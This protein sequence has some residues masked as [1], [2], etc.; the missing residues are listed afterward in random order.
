MHFEEVSPEFREESSGRRSLQWK[1]GAVMLLILASA[2]GGLGVYAALF[3][4]LLLP[5]KL[6]P[7]AVERTVRRAELLRELAKEG[8]RPV[9]V[10]GSSVVLEGVD[11]EIIEALLPGDTAVYNIAESNAGLRNLMMNMP[12]IRT[13]QPQVL[14]CCLRRSQLDADRLSELPSELLIGYAYA[15]YVDT[16]NHQPAWIFERLS[17]H[18]REALPGTAVT[19]LLASRIFLLRSVEEKLRHLARP[20]L[21]NEGFASNFVSPWRYT[22]QVPKDRLERSI[23]R[24]GARFAQLRFDPES[25][26]A[27]VLKANLKVCQQAGIRFLLVLTPENPLIQATL[28]KQIGDAFDAAVRDFTTEHGGEMFRM[29][30]N[31]FSPGDFLDYVH[32]NASGREIFSRALAAALAGSK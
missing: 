1:A 26:V 8:S 5:S 2:A 29:D 23:R 28:P 15:D 24:A 18:E 6:V 17:Q 3:T 11:S 25:P 22:R 9:L 30:T 7:V 27:D 20:D 19:K 4:Y 12:L 21:R 10:F 13:A 32:V 16:A 31:L 14:A